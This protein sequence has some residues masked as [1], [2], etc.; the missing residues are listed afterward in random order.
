MSLDDLSPRGFRRLPRNGTCFLGG[1]HGVLLSPR[2]Q[3]FRGFVI[4]P[5]VRGCGGRMGV[6]GVDVQIRSIVMVALGAL[7][8]PYSG[9]RSRLVIWSLPPDHSKR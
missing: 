1:F 3:L 2:N 8:L 6:R 7:C 5:V 9:K 4:A